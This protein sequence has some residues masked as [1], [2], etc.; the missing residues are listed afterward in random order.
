MKS[1]LHTLQVFISSTPTF[2]PK[3]QRGWQAR[4]GGRDHR[5]DQQQ[6][7]CKKKFVRYIYWIDIVFILTFSHSCLRVAR[8]PRSGTSRTR[9]TAQLCRSLTS[10]TSWSL[11]PSIMNLSRLGQVYLMRW[12]KLLMIIDKLNSSLKRRKIFGEVWSMEEKKNRKG[13]GGK[14]LEKE[15]IWSAEE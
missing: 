3:A 10:S 7:F 13:K 11:G 2:P 14:Y 9:P 4:Q 6:G 8:V 1:V 5:V 15:N 12:I